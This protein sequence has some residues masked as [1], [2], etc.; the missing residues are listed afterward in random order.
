MKSI[1][2]VAIL[3]INFQV[4]L[5]NLEKPIIIPNDTLIRHI[6]TTC[7]PHYIYIEWDILRSHLVH[8]SRNLVHQSRINL[9]GFLKGPKLPVKRCLN[10]LNYCTYEEGYCGI[11]SQTITKRILKLDFSTGNYYKYLVLH[12]VEDTNCSCMPRKDYE[13]VTNPPTSIPHITNITQYYPSSYSK[14]KQTSKNY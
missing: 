6:E 5:A 14:S 8:Q 3:F 7:E 11:S 1:L 2:Y 4:S 13:T 10:F 9:A 12:F